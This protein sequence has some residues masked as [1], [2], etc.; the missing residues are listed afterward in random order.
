M[1]TMREIFE[2]TQWPLLEEEEAAFNLIMEADDD[3]IMEAFTEEDAN[4]LDFL[5]D[6]LDAAARGPL[7]EEQALALEGLGAW[8]KKK[9]GAVKKKLAPGTKMVFGRVVK[10]GK[11][12]GGAAKAVGKAA[13]TA[14]RGVQA[15]SFRFTAAGKQARQAAKKVRDTY[16]RAAGKKSY[17]AAKGTYKSASRAGESHKYAAGQAAKAQ[18]KTDKRAKASEYGPLDKEGKAKAKAVGGKPQ[19]SKKAAPKKGAPVAKGKGKK[20]A[21]VPKGKKGTGKKKRK[22]ESMQ[23]V[24]NLV[25]MSDTAI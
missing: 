10:V 20:A 15:H 23:D 6:L 25:E 4:R 9:A 14:K 19:R 8:I 13:V 12:V 22:T 5:A 11:A 2:E 18:S 1:T 24:F 21:T 17:G 3:E 16:G 7:S